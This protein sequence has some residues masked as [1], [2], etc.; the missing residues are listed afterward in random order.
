MA[1]TAHS[2]EAELIEHFDPPE[3]LEKKLDTLASWVRESK[4]F[5]AFTGAGISTSAGIPDFRGPDGIWTLAAQVGLLH[6]ALPC[7]C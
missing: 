6:S 3:L 7:C 4:C 5:T 2:S 1:S